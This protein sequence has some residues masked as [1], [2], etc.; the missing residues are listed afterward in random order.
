M[1][2]KAL[3]PLLASVAAIAS[4]DARFPSKAELHAK[5]AEAAARIR[6]NMPRATGSGVKNITF[7]DP[8]ASQFYVDGTTIP[9]VDFDVGPSWSGLIPIS[10]D[11][12]ETRK[13]FFWFF[14]PGPQGSLD[15]LIFWTNGGPGCSSLE[16][17]LQENGPF[18]WSLGQARPT[19]NEFS[20]TN[21]S[22]ILFLEQPV[23]TGFS[24]GKPNVKNENDVAAQIVGFFQQFLDIFKELQGKNLYLTGESYA[25][26]YVPY[27]A[28]YIY[29]HPTDLNLTLNGFWVSD[30]VLGWDVVQEQI[31]AVDFVHKYEGVFSFN[32]TFL[33]HLDSVA[34]K[35]NYTGYVAKHVTF[36]PKGLLPLPGKSTEF[37]HGCDVWDAI[38]DAALLVNPAFNIYRIFDTWPILW[39]VL[40]FPGSFPQQQSPIYFDR[41]D[42]K[43]AIH[44][45]ANVS[46]AECSD[47]D[48]FPRGDASLPPAFTVLPNAIEKSKRS[49]IVHG[50]ADF[51]L[52]AEGTR[53]VIQNMTWNGKQ[54][55]HTPIK[56][57]SF[58]VEGMGAMG[59]THTERGL[60]YYEVSLSGHMVP[61]FSPKAAFQIMSYLMGFRD[62]P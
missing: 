11:P 45:P 18:Q 47:V 54:G 56:N 35:C 28:N 14:P 37:D 13:L 2:H 51:I 9:D 53:I 32:Q 5:Q 59:N 12:N 1:F 58:V 33:A 30:P 50:L 52:I 39:D 15:D 16:G 60:T 38:F 46:W 6:A 41:A 8:R 23:G 44:A 36:P 55:F 21:L 19:Q 43:K 7:S 29:E 27:L 49:V 61:Q 26:M 24:V 48:V 42:V 17:L 31:P 25:G 62:T 22:S 40:G 57:D 20:W 34:E 10:S 4:V 3:L